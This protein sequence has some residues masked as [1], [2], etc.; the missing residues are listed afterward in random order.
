MIQVSSTFHLRRKKQISLEK[1][2]FSLILWLMGM[3]KIQNFWPFLKDI[4]CDLF[5]S[6]HD[7]YL[8]VCSV[9]F[10]LR[11]YGPNFHAVFKATKLTKISPKRK[12]NIYQNNLFIP[13]RYLNEAFFAL[14][15]KNYQILTSL[16][17]KLKFQTKRAK[18]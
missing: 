15:L 13:K 14:P 9:R 17:N 4:P 7:A 16:F 8:R 10:Q 2:L 12:N 5:W 11:N 1:H 18:N 6:L 3:T